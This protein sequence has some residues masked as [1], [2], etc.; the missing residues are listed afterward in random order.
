MELIEEHI[1]VSF[2]AAPP[3][4]DGIAHKNPMYQRDVK[5]AID[6][7]NKMR[8]RYGEEAENIL[9]EFYEAVHDIEIFQCLH[10]FQQGYLAAER[11]LQKG[12]KEPPKQAN[13]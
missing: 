2:I 1:V 8:R 7:K 13:Q 4:G 11:K 5:R 10:Y 6:I 9:L 3:F 12:E